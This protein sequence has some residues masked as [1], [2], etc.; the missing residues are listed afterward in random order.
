MYGTFMGKIIGT[1]TDIDGS[2]QTVG[3]DCGSYGLKQIQFE[4]LVIQDDII[5]FIPR[6][7][8][9]AQRLIREKGLTL[10]RLKALIDIVTENNEMKDDAE[11]IHEKYKSKLMMLDETEKQINDKLDS[12]SL[13]LSEQIKSLKIFLFD[14]KVQYKSNEISTTVFESI[15]L[16]TKDLMEHINHESLEISNIKNRLNNLTLNNHQDELTQKQIQ[17]SALSY[18]DSNESQ[19]ELKLPEVPDKEPLEQLEPQSL[20]H[21]SLP[22]TLES[23]I[24]K[25]RTLSNT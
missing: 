21:S 13:E 22:N 5:I 19:T 14:A 10:R 11:I 1:T 25:D 4:Q 18:L 16:Y 9:D 7:R 23:D 8:L 20:I 3:I 15:N 6:W 2:I 24:H 17:E 12:R